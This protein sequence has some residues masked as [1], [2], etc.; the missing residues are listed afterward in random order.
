MY[1]Y[2]FIIIINYC[3]L[4]SALAT[5]MREKQRSQSGVLS[6]LCTALHQSVFLMIANHQHQNALKKCS[7]FNYY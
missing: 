1:M 3:K 5:Y 6:L 4:L 2:L 7:T